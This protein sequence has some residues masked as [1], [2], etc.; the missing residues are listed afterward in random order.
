[1]LFIIKKISLMTNPIV[2]MTKNPRAHDLV[3]VKNSNFN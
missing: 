2:P 1:M 3:I